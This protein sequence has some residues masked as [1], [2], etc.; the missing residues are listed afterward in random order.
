M[1]IISILQMAAGATRRKRLRRRER[2]ALTRARLIEGAARVFAERGFHGASVEE[3]AEEAGY[4]T[5]AVYSNFSGKEQLFL[6]VLD[7]HITRRLDSVED[8]IARA[9]G[10]RE[11]AQAG[12]RNWIEFLEA[13]RHWYPLFIE[14]WAYAQRDPPLRRQL[15]E[16]FRAFPRANARLLAEGLAEVGLSVRADTIDRA[17]LLL[18]ALSDGLALIKVMDPD[19]VPAELFSETL[20]FLYDRLVERS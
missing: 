11:R 12:A 6:A 8:A 17:G 18:T 13:N 5:G 7:E 16:R 4:S 14:F 20:A 15:A 1:L 10:P 9:G 3:I 19:A 2:K